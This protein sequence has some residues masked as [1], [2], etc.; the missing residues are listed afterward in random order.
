VKSNGE[1][2]PTRMLIGL[3][4]EWSLVSNAAQYPRVMSICEDLLE[5]A[6]PVLADVSRAVIADAEK[7]RKGAN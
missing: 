2:D 4:A 3:A 7:K 1:I 5:S 6:D